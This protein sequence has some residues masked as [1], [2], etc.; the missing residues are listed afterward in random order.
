MKRKTL[1][2]AA[3][4]TSGLVVG[5]AASYS[6]EKQEISSRNYC[7]NVEQ[8]IEENMS[9]GFI[10][11]YPPGVIGVNLSDKVSESADVKCVCRKKIGER[12]QMLTFTTS[13]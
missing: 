1:V 3:A 6:I 8:G 10:N 12:I 5:G 4:L 2:I 7:A 13:N 9:E 11:C